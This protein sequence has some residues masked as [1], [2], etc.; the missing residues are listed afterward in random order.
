MR[1]YKRGKQITS[2]DEMM[3]NDLIIVE[4]PDKRKEKTYHKGW[5]QS[6]QVRMCKQLIDNYQVYEAEKTLWAQADKK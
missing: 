6:W 2:L 4:T 3:S 5:F 1:K